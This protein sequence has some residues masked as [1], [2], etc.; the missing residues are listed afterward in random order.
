MRA[1]SSQL[2]WQLKNSSPH[3][4]SWPLLTQD[5]WPALSEMLFALQ[6]RIF[7]KQLSS[8]FWRELLKNLPRL[9]PRCRTL[10]FHF[11]NILPLNVLHFV[12]LLLHSFA[13]L[14]ICYVQMYFALPSWNELF[15]AFC[16]FAAF[17]CFPVCDATFKCTT[18]CYFATFHCVPLSYTA[19]CSNVLR[20]SGLVKRRDF[21]LH[22]FTNLAI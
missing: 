9:H 8:K 18:F 7:G 16:Y 6:R 4:I 22:W 11:A 19:I 3:L 2:G 17:K 21:T 20:L 12:T 13:T 5:T 14:L 15:C 1:S 10:T